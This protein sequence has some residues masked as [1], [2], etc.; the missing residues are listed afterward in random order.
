MLINRDTL[1]H[2]SPVKTI[3]LFC[4]LF[5]DIFLP[6]AYVVR[7]E[8]FDTCRSVCPH[9]E[10]YSGQVQMGVTPARYDGGIPRPGPDGGEYS[11][12]VQLGGGYP[13]QLQLGYPPIR[14]GR[15]IPLPGGTPPRVTDGV[16]DTPRSV[17]L[18]CSRRKTFS[19][20]KFSQGKRHR[21]LYFR[22]N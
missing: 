18:L 10:E 16:L 19:C 4:M 11:S 20:S 9:L 17:C 3:Q 7:R 14:P 5:N 2:P 13:S 8:G 21:N 15:G 1:L 22:I 6:T 12:Q